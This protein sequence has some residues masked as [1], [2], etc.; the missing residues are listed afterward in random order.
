MSCHPERSRGIPWNYLKLTL[1]DSSTP[2]RFA[3]NDG[4][5]N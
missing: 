1:R 5:L 4:Y 3:Q 2:L